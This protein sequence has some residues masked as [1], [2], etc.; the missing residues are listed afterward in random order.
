MFLAS[1]PVPRDSLVSVSSIPTYI[2]L[3]SS[4]RTVFYGEEVRNRCA[5]KNIS[6]EDVFKCSMTLKR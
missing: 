3:I 2:V 1:R 5:V 4:K 6:N